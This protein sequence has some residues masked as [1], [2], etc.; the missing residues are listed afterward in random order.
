MSHSTS[1]CRAAYPIRRGAKRSRFR[2]DALGHTARMSEPL[3][4]AP[5]TEDSPDP[6]PAYVSNG[7]IGVRVR[8]VPLRTGTAAVSGLEGEHP[9]ARVACV[10]RGPYPVMGDIV[11]N[12]V[13]MSERW[14][15]VRSE[16]QRY[17][18][19]TGEL[20]SRFRFTSQGVTVSVDVLTF[21]SRTQPSLSAQEVTVVADHACAL[22][23]SV[24]I[25]PTEITGRW[26]ERR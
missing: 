18:F 2:D 24:G 19:A 21:C 7:V 16:E 25:D 1:R 26:I 11:V 15:L 4:P 17:D 20:H 23:V 3:S 6:L 14:N 22:E 5:V 10:P 12:E 8:D 9:V 13:R